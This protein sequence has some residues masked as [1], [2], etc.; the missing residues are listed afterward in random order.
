MLWWCFWF[1]DSWNHVEIILR[2]KSFV[3]FGTSTL[4][5]GS[6]RVLQLLTDLSKLT[7]NG[8]EGNPW[9]DSLGSKSI[10]V[11]WVLDFWL[12]K[13]TYLWFEALTM[14]INNMINNYRKFKHYFILFLTIKYWWILRTLFLIELWSTEKSN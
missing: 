5:G 11:S 8:W 9:L 7:G 1:I 10:R 6:L 13:D 2:F 14:L 3:L 12:L 4:L